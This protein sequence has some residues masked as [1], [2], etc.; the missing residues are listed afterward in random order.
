MGHPWG[1]NSNFDPP[2]GGLGGSNFHSG[3]R[4]ESY[5]SNKKKFK[6]FAAFL[7]KLCTFENFAMVTSYSSTI[8][9]GSAKSRRPPW[10]GLGGSGGVKLFF[11][12]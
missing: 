6:P 2:G 12:G 11:C 4:A 5:L 7:A 10:G 9:V 8:E 1:G 3:G